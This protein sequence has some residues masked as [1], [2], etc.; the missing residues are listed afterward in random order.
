[1]FSKLQLEILKEEIE[2]NIECEYD[3]EVVNGMLDEEEL[4]KKKSYL[5]ELININQIIC[6]QLGVDETNTLLYQSCKQD[7]L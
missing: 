1:M 4:T 3:S 5:R 2:C 7:V 6:T